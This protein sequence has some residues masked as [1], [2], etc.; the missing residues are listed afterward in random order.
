M[1]VL[2]RVWSVEK[3][4]IVLTVIIKTMPNTLNSTK[5]IIVLREKP[6]K[7]SWHDNTKAAHVENQAVQKSTANATRPACCA[8]IFANASNVKTTNPSATKRSF[9]N[10]KEI[11]AQLLAKEPP[12][13]I[14]KLI[15]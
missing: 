12:S 14:L 4:A 6:S 9:L 8:G 11:P 5:T 13:V 10:L 3:I 1:S 15:F 2:Q 7:S